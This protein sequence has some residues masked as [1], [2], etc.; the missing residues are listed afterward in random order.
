MIASTLGWPDAAA[1]AVIALV[2][3]R[4]LVTFI[5][6]SLSEPPPIFATVDDDDDDDSEEEAPQPGPDHRNRISMN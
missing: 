6:L 2:A 4:V 1:I 3:G 5:R